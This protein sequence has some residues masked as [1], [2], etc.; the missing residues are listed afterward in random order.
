MYTL[1]QIQKIIDTS[2]ILMSIISTT[3]KLIQSGDLKSLPDINSK[4]ASLC[5]AQ[6]CRSVV[7]D[8]QGFPDYCCVSV[9]NIACHGTSQSWS[10]PLKA[11]DTVKLDLAIEHGGW[12]SD[13]CR[14][15]FV[16]EGSQFNTL[17]YSF[18][19]NLVVQTIDTLNKLLYQRWLEDEAYITPVDIA[20]IVNEKVKKTVCYAC[21]SDYGGHGVGRKM[22]ENPYI[23]YDPGLVLEKDFR[24]TNGSVF[25]IEPIITKKPKKTALRAGRVKTKILEDKWSVRTKEVSTQYEETVAIINNRIEVLTQSSGQRVAFG[26]P[27]KG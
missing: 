23:P 27:D 4:I 13:T 15:F 14:T 22:H 17:M 21:I 3:G 8:F 26:D 16:G 20:T 18:N 25:T 6:A 12:V 11:G 1:F 19:R 10:P 2:N 9:N 5:E 7:K 24:L